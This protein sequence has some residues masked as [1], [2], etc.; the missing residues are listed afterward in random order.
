[1]NV[2]PVKDIEAFFRRMNA[3]EGVCHAER[4][5]TTTGQLGP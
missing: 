5:G 4:D 3:E 2:E 1:M